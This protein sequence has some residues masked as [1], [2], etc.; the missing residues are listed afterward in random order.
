MRFSSRS[1]VDQMFLVAIH[2][3]SNGEQQELQRMRHRDRLLAGDAG[4]ESAVD[5]LAGP[6]PPF[7]TLRHAVMNAAGTLLAT[8]GSPRQGGTA[9]PLALRIWDITALESRF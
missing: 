2:P 5:D 7:R 3:A 6:R 1:I 8:N 9:S 4:T